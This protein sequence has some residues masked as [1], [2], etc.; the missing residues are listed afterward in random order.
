M[1]H[2]HS[3]ECRR[4]GELVGGLYGVAI[5]GVFFGES[6]F[7]FARDASKVALVHLVARLRLG[8][9]RLLDTQ[10]VTAHL[11]QFGAEEIPRHAYRAHADGGAGRA[12]PLAAGAG[13]AR[14]GVSRAR[15]ASVRMMGW[16]V[17]A[18]ALVVVLCAAAGGERPVLRPIRDVDVTYAVDA[19]GGTILHERLRWDVAAQMLRV[20][21]P[22]RGLYVI[23]DLAARRMSTVRTAEQAVIEMAAPE[24]VTGMADSAAAG[25]VRRGTDTVAGLACTEWDMTDVAGQ[26][27]RVCLTEDGVL[28]R[29]RL[30]DRT[31]LRAETVQYGP[32]DPGVFRIPVGYTHR[33][34]AAQP[35]GPQPAG[36]K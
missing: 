32:L 8:G 13:G 30:G 22:T 28:L 21:P 20:D 36:P 27:T 10:F 17:A 9:F 35:A 7:S 25:A 1:G 24:G 11:A 2:A 23:I 12:G 3:V 6:M 4:D 5:G 18:G 29:A 34:M 33:W 19:G 31:L 26:A 14:R 16:R 15:R